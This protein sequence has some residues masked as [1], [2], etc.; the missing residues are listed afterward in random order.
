[1]SSTTRLSVHRLFE[2][3]PTPSPATY[4]FVQSLLTFEMCVDVGEKKA[5]IAMP[6]G[7]LVAVHVAAD[8]TAG[9]AWETEMNLKA[10]PAH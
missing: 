8:V 9:E 5:H 3:S 2:D 10:H 1:M 6:C 4:R 7:P